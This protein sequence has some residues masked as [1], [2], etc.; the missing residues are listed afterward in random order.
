[1]MTLKFGKYQIFKITTLYL[2]EILLLLYISSIIIISMMPIG[3][4]IS[5][6]L[7][8]LF[9][10]YFLLI[11]VF[12]SNG[13][14]SINKE[15]KFIIV[16]LFFCV[17]SGL[18]ALKI[19]LVFDKLLTIIQLILFFVA[20]YTVILK[21]KITEKQIFYTFILSTIIVILYGISTYE[22]VSGFAYKNRIASTTG[23]PN[24]LA[25]FGSFAYIFCL[26]LIV[27]ERKVVK[28]LFLLILLSIII[29]G[30]VNTHSRQ[31]IVMLMGSTIVYG[32]IRTVH[33]YKNSINKLKFLRTGIII[34]IGIVVI[35]F[36]GFQYLVDSAYYFRIKTLLS[37]AKI[38]I[39]SSTVNM[40]KVV[41]YSAY[42]RSQFIIYG[43]KIWF[44]NLFFGVGLDNFRVIIKKYW[45]I[46][47]PLYS[48]NN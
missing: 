11:S 39:N 46:S 37:F 30:I 42:E 23:N 16:W 28:I 48:H 5:K 14:I 12:W 1:M 45:P 33:N 22:P 15:F 13:K 8:L 34:T 9:L 32:I 35:S 26:Y 20:G 31:G 41:D 21:G 17:L 24:N 36:F 6:G 3:N 29:Y 4:I 7:G 10:F 2:V 18:F 27:N 25:V 40:A 47:N 44:D 19:D 38:G 43:V